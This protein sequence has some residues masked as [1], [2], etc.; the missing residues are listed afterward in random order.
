MWYGVLPCDDKIK[1]AF[2]W[3]YTGGEK[4]VAGVKFARYIGARVYVHLEGVAHWRVGAETIESWG[5]HR[6]VKLTNE[7]ISKCVQDYREWMSTAFDADVCSIN[8][9]RQLEIVTDYIFDGKE[10][11]NC[12]KLTCGADARYALTLPDYKK[13]NLFVTVSRIVQNKRILHIAKALALLK[14]K[15]YRHKGSDFP[16]WVIIGYGVKV[17]VDEILEVTKAHGISLTIVAVFDVTKWRF[18]KKAR[19]MLQGVSGIPPAE[20]LLCGTPVLSF[21]YPS[22]VEKFG[23]AIYWAENNDVEHYAA[24]IKWMLDNPD[25]IQSHTAWG[26]DQLLT[27]KLFATTQEL[28]ARKYEQIFQDNS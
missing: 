18:I 5:F 17:V 26:L 2:D 28:L 1:G 4:S 22:I 10:L 7:D 6:E 16:Q 3:V 8:G 12:Y 27:G 21:N 20:G 14:N 9:T 25:T 11:P 23:N 24:R 15:Y 19:I 13:D